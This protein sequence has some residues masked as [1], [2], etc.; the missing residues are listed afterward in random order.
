MTIQKDFNHLAAQAL[1]NSKIYV[2]SSKVDICN[3]NACLQKSCDM[4]ND[5]N[6]KQRLTLAFPKHTILAFLKFWL[7]FKITKEVKL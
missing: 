1:T 5:D 3:I 2:T 6:L 4:R 7:D